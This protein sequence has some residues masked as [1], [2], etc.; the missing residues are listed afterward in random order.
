MR[1]TNHELSGLKAPLHPSHRICASRYR[2]AALVFA[3][4]A[5]VWKLKVWVRVEGHIRGADDGAARHDGWRRWRRWVPTRI[6]A[7][8]RNGR[9]VRPIRFGRAAG[10]SRW[11]FQCI[12]EVPQSGGRRLRSTRR[13]AAPGPGFHG[14][15]GALSA[16]C[17]G[18]KELSESFSQ[19][20]GSR[21]AS[22]EHRC[23]H[24]GC[25]CWPKSWLAAWQASRQHLRHC[26]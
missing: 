4:T 19:A 10:P 12:L 1:L 6:D 24:P 15:G 8:L 13:L 22:V 3:W 16:C 25:R 17:S 5:T 7:S 21:L 9:K 11:N 2:T 20:L 23:P 26:P 14:L 18:G